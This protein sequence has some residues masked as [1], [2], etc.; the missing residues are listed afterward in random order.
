VTPPRTE[1]ANRDEL[2]RDTA[3]VTVGA[4]QAEP[5]GEANLDSSPVALLRHRLDDTEP[6]AQR[7]QGRIP[8]APEGRLAPTE[9]IRT[10][11]GRSLLEVVEAQ[12]LALRNRELPDRAM[13][14][15]G[16][17]MTDRLFIG[18]SAGAVRDFE[19]RLR[20]QGGRRL[21]PL[22]PQLVDGASEGGV[23]DPASGVVN[24]L[25]L[26]AGPRVLRQRLLDQFLGVAADE[27]LGELMRPQLAGKRRADCP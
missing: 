4:S 5:G 6:L 24:H 1:S 21:P 9:R 15:L 19:R 2:I 8:A 3:S 13:K 23:D 22:S 11:A 27:R 25:A 16:L 10:I 17:D 14:L 12:C 26:P 7:P 20:R 18:W